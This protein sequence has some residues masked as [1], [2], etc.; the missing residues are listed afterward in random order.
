[1]SAKNNHPLVI[2][3]DCT[4]RV[5]T[6]SPA[7]SFGSAFFDY[8][9][10][11][12]I[13]RATKTVT[14]ASRITGTAAPSRARQVVHSGDVLV[15][16]VRPNLNAVARVKE[17][18]HKAVA[19]TGFC[20]LRPKARVLSSKYLLHWVKS[21]GFINDMVARATGASYPAVSD[22]TVKSALIPLPSMRE[23]ERIAEV[24]DAADALCRK[25]Q[26][27][28]QKYNELAQS[29]FYEL[30]GDPVRNDKN[31]PVKKLGALGTIATGNTPSRAVSKFYGSEVEWVK[32][33]NISPHSDYPSS[34]DEY[35]SL[36]GAKVGRL[37][38]AGS[39]LIT[40]IAGSEKSIGNCCLTDRR[41]AFNQQMNAFTPGPDYH[42]HFALPLFRECKKMVQD[43]STQ[44]M[45][46]MITKSKLSNLEFI[47]PPMEL[48]TKYHT[49]YQQLRLISQKH[50]VQATQSES[51]LRSFMNQ[52][53]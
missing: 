34:A 41:V 6:C 24:L 9:D 35:L 18:Y 44:G 48:Q 3:G 20:V 17:R 38:N 28:L 37:V 49:Y 22:K 14:S 5:S 52:Y 2:L 43:A 53:F 51:L 30:F 15:S 40:C 36:E 21:E 29:L 13:D 46:R 42:Q 47:C 10:I 12:A 19:S 45:K 7:T 8:I 50:R 39:I 1:M 32:T 26:I 23:Q 25:D 31:W 4:E 11:A 33:D 16:T 27:L